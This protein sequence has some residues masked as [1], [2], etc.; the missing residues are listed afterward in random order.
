MPDSLE[1]VTV[2][3]GLNETLKE[4]FLAATKLLPE[5]FNKLMA[6]SPP[7]LISH[8]KPDHRVDFRFVEYAVPKEQVFDFMMRHIQAQHR[9]GWRDIGTLRLID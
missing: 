2:V 9:P 3:E 5:R 7:Q 6:D 4:R 8:W 1:L